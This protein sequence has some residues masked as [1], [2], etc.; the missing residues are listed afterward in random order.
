M[1]KKGKGMRKKK[2]KENKKGKFLRRQERQKTNDRQDKKRQKR[3]NNLD[4]LERAIGGHNNLHSHFQRT[5]A[6]QIYFL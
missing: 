3:D 4:R 2:G 5:T 1:K 6:N